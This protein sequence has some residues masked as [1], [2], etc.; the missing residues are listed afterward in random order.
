MMVSA[1][2]A[3]LRLDPRM[4]SMV[5]ALIVVAIVL[6]WLT[7]GLFLS[8]ENLYN[9]SI[10]TCVIAVMACGM[11]YVIVARQID[12]SCGSLLAFTGMAAAWTQTRGFPPG[13]TA[14]WITSIFVALAIGALVGSVQG[15]LIAWARIP[16]FVVT[17]AG[18]LIY[19]GA[20]FLV[21]DGQ[22]L[23]PL[24]P[25]YQML[26]GGVNGSLG[27]TGSIVL[28]LVA[29]A[30]VIWQRLNVRRNQR[31][32]GIEPAPVVADVLKAVVMCLSI[33]GFVTA[34]CL[35]PDFVNKD[36]AGNPQGRGIGIPVLIL[37]V[38]VIIL[39][40]VAQRTRY[41]RYVFAFGGNPGAALLS[42][43]PTTRLLWS[44]FVL[45]GVLSAIAA[46]ITTARLAS[47]ANSIGQLAELNVIAATVIG[48]TSLSGGLGSVPGAVLG[49][50][51]IQSLDNGMVL[52]DVSSPMRQIFIG[53]VLIAAVWFDVVYQKR[54]VR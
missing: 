14:G 9:L 15:A 4:T 10:Q 2:L 18:L 33:A 6:Q 29:V 19:R 30:W 32:Y 31:R 46:V 17:L 13:S 36:A 43:L 12:L 49:A 34:M 25:T 22:T 48:G 41:G 39:T 42:G 50:L 8:A 11:V 54:S 16:A 38:V 3:R 44:L 5:G 20:A 28:G 53:V 7:G 37:I 47:G 1:W 35:S 52:L 23:A 45:T 26:G 40:F 21:S 24:H 27:V 51:L